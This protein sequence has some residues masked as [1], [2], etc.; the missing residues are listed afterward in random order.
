ML[1]R[2]KGFSQL[3]L[4]HVDNRKFDFGFWELLQIPDLNT[5]IKTKESS[6]T[7]QCCLVELPNS[8]EESCQQLG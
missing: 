1:Y 3:P 5:F 8:G 6:D 4:C 7:L 2:F